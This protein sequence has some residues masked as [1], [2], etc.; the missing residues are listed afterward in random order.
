[1]ANIANFAHHAHK[2]TESRYRD[3]FE[4]VIPDYWPPSLNQT[5]MA[6]WSR[7]RKHKKQALDLLHVYALQ[8]AGGPLPVFKGPVRLTLVR[9]WGKRQRALDVDNLYGS[10]KP[11]VDAMRAAKRG[12]NGKV[13]EGGLGLIENDDPAQVALVVDQRKNDGGHGVPADQLAA[14]I[15]IEGRLAE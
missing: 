2:M 11:L 9:L 5:Q 14:H 8:A 13:R 12:R 1:M 10:V 7:N 4:L 3:R 15:L 6:H